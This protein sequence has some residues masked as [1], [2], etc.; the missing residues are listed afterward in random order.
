MGMCVVQH[1]KIEQN[2]LKWNIYRHT[3]N[4]LWWAQSHID[5]HTHTHLFHSVTHL[6]ARTHIVESSWSWCRIYYI[7]TPLPHRKHQ[8]KS[9]NFAL[10]FF[11]LLRYA[12]A[13]SQNHLLTP[14]SDERSQA[15]SWPKGRRRR[16]RKNNEKTRLET[17]TIKRTV[18]P[19]FFRYVFRFITWIGV[20]SWHD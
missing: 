15:A 3:D 1:I 8:F 4:I 7:A 19:P 12:K 9:L 16:R 14:L 6:E 10:T 17:L 13:H 5:K 20:V 11:F 2:K 18:N